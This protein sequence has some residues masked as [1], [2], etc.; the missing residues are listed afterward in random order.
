MLSHAA[1]IARAMSER[2]LHSSP[3]IARG[4]LALL[5]LSLAVAAPVACNS[6]VEGPEKVVGPECHVELPTE[7]PEPAP[8]F[9]DVEPIFHERCGGDCHTGAPGGEWPLDTYRH[10]ADWNDVVRD[11]LRS[12]AMPPL[13]AGVTLTDEERHAILTWILCGFPE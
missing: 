4:L 5:V 11:E 6:T 13:D 9:A 8:R 12:C 1:F 3:M 10:I 2:K 7:C